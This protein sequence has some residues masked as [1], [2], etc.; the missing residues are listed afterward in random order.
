MI[1]VE[2]AIPLLDKLIKETEK[3]LSKI[4]RHKVMGYSNFDRK[5]D[6]YKENVRLIKNF[7]IFISEWFNIKLQYLTYK[8]EL[9]DPIPRIVGDGKK[10][11]QYRINLRLWNLEKSYNSY[12]VQLPR[13][14]WNVVMSLDLV[15]QQ[16][17]TNDE[18]I[19]PLQ[20]SLWGFSHFREYCYVYL[21]LRT[22]NK[23][24]NI[25]LPTLLIS[26]KMSKVFID[27]KEMNYPDHIVNALIFMLETHYQNKLYFDRKEL[28]KQIHINDLKKPL[29][30][31]FR[32]HKPL[33]SFVNRAKDSNGRFITNKYKLD[34]NLD[35][36]RIE[37]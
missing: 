8:F 15:N 9:D 24:K 20:A 25:Q 2:N 7:E 21:N 10:G 13:E 23:S 5:K 1:I 6:I 27:E 29:R 35:E 22:K 11:Y 19:I 30:D 37:Y 28:L 34:V 17:R 18:S 3:S 14:L 26:K 4:P 33:D 36:S 32:Y 12:V 31:I 16:R